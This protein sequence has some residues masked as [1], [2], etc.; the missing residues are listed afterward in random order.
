MLPRLR[1]RP[2][3]I[4]QQ[5]PDRCS[6]CTWWY[7]LPRL[8]GSQKTVESEEDHEASKNAFRGKHCRHAPFRKTEI[9]PNGRPAKHHAEGEKNAAHHFRPKAVQ[10]VQKVAEDDFEFLFH[11][12]S[13]VHQRSSTC[14]AIIA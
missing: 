6:S 2:A 12:G 5:V 1:D 3:N 4:A 9:L 13:A 10:R 14:S 8:P 7:S 11:G